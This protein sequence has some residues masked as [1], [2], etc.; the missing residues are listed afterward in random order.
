M[1]W[2]N[3]HGHVILNEDSPPTFQGPQ[4]RSWI[5]VTCCSH[6]TP[7][8]IGKWST[9]QN[10]SSDHRSIHI[11]LGYEDDPADCGRVEVEGFATRKADWKAFERA[12][13]DR[14]I[15]DEWSEAAGNGSLESD[16]NAIA[17]SLLQAAAEVFKPREA[18]RKYKPWW[19][20]ELT[21]IKRTVYRAR[22][23]YQSCHDPEAREALRQRY[24]QVRSE[25]KRRITQGRKDAWRSFVER[26]SQK[27]PWGIPY[28]VAMGKRVRNLGL[29]AVKVGDR[30]ATTLE[31][32]A[33]LYLR[34]TYPPDSP[35]GDSEEDAFVRSS[36][37]A[38]T[39]DELMEPW[40]IWD[41]R[42][43]IGAMRGG[44]APGM[45]N[46]SPGMVKHM[47][48]DMED[49][50]LLAMNRAL[51]EGNFPSVWKA[52]DL[53]LIPKGGGRDPSSPKSYRPISLLPVLSKVLERMI[54]FSMWTHLENREHHRQFGSRK[55]RGTVDA[56]SQLMNDV[57]G[58]REKYVAIVAIDI[59]SAF[60][61]VWWP[62]V[63]SE[64]QQAEVPS[65]LYEL[66][67]S[68]LLGR[69]ATIVGKSYKVTASIER[70]SPQGSVL[71]PTLWKLVFARVLRFLDGKF[72]A[73]AYV[74][75]LALVVS[76]PSRD[77]LQARLNECLRTVDE[78][79]KSN[80]MEI[81][82][83]KTKIVLVKGKTDR[84]HPIRVRLRSDMI[85][86]QTEM[87]YLGVVISHGFNMAPHVH[88]ITNKVET[89]L[90]RL[91]RLGGATWGVRF[92][93][94]RTLYQSVVV[95]IIRY[96]SELWSPLLKNSSWDKLRSL[97]RKAL[98]R[99]TRAYRTVSL[100][101]AQVLAGVLPIDLVLREQGY[102]RG[103][104]TL[105][106]AGLPPRIREG[107]EMHPAQWRRIL[108]QDSIDEW[109]RRWQISLHSPILHKF[110]PTVRDRLQA[111]WV[112]PDYWLSQILTGHGGFRAKLHQFKRS[113]TIHCPHCGE[114][115]NVEHVILSCAGLDRERCQLMR[116][117]GEIPL[118]E[119]DIP[120]LVSSKANLAAFKEF[121]GAWKTLQ[122]ADHF[123]ISRDRRR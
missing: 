80:K 20:P 106:L 23:V 87:V 10:T 68:Y 47:G 41:L 27:N 84:R 113:P 28:I 56:I 120:S 63:K 61:G 66:M 81:A 122:G 123:K 86:C 95:G 117:I 43:A 51:D 24:A 116:K 99:M 38:P 33:Q 44:S 69:T 16:I 17:D 1:D 8:I 50:V 85:Q 77:A 100:D 91:S 6:N 112:E 98:I 36:T 96:A 119:R 115:D 59:S 39:G 88:H 62:F 13:T 58:C 93:V 9:A 83:P 89:N 25:Y 60:D 109:D 40:D 107:V 46:I 57:N 11:E 31:E 105:G 49:R 82:V 5:D 90:N 67:S 12:V 29:E 55:G 26:E 35:D 37:A 45:D 114:E 34:A 74:D 73:I 102:R 32:S 104:K 21:E 70:G 65:N 18:V 76:A 71:G 75:D 79:C 53:R 118:L 2:M 121:I 110:F 52:A 94:T 92:P 101:A 4:G 3:A 97:Q 108:L 64:L 48:P 14:C 103:Y 54:L 22:R 7:R 42:R 19:S 111:D 72:P 78:E 30:V 15:G